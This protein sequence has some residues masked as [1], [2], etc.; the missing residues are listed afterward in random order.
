MNKKHLIT[1]VF[2]AFSSLGQTVLFPGVGSGG[3][4]D[5][6][7]G[8][9]GNNGLPLEVTFNVSGLDP[10]PPGK[11]EVDLDIT[12]S[13]VGDV[14]VTLVA[15]D[16]TEFNLFSRTRVTI[17]G[18]CGDSSDLDGAYTFA[19]SAIGTNWWDEAFVQGSGDVLTTDIYRTTETGG[20]GQ[21]DPA[22]VT[23]LTAAFAGIADSNGTWIL[24]VFDGGVGD[25][26]TVT[27]ADLLLESGPNPDIIYMNGFEAP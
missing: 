17:A 16:A 8:G 23:D 24:R 2:L 13:W 5:G 6:G 20:D 14:T 12:H 7:V 1:I 22:P 10:Y 3:I 18:G 4:P 21:V 26:G 15:P 27:S 9:C 11:V 19:D 25:L